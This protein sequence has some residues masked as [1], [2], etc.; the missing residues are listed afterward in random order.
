MVFKI[1]I[2]DGSLGGKAGNTGAFLG[3]FVKALPSDV[4]V[5]YVELR[6]VEDVKGLE[7]RMRAAD[8]FVVASGTYWQSWGSPLQRFFEEGTDWE[9]SDVWLGK[10]VC[11]LVTMH[12]V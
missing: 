6:D 10:P 5:E 8:G 2:L 3:H 11:T 1:V 12:S 9:L 7:A 4:A